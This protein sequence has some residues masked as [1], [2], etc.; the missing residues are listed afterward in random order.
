M[1]G[2]F[3]IVWCLVWGVLLTAPSAHGITK[4]A[5]P[6]QLTEQ[7]PQQE[8]AK[9]PGTPV[10]DG[11]T[12]SSNEV[13]EE[14]PPLK[15]GVLDLDAVMHDSKVG[16]DLQAQIDAKRE[17]FKKVVEAF[18][19]TLREKEKALKEQ[20]TNKTLSDEALLKMRKE[21]D[22]AVDEVQKKIRIESKVLQDA[23]HEARAR[24]MQEI[25]QLVDIIVEERAITLVIPKTVV[26]YRHDAYEFTEELVRRLDKAYPKA[27]VSFR[28]GA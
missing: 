19:G 9:S 15:V 25:M 6:P 21:F 22:E 23:F 28:K 11:K 17:E 16:Q 14:D 5:S 13:S 3:L 27:V 2:A 26:M 8:P 20:E 18:E 24:I 7:R 4:K 1:R 10:R 12:T